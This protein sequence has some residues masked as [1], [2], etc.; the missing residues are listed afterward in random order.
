MLSPQRITY[1][2]ILLCGAGVLFLIGICAPLM[3][4]TKLM[5][6]TTTVSLI[7]AVWQLFAER[8]YVLGGVVGVF[9]LLGPLGKLT[10]VFLAC[11]HAKRSTLPWQRTLYWLALWG[12]WSMLD[13]FIVALLV[14]AAKVQGFVAVNVNYGLYAFAASVILLHVAT[15]WAVAEAP[16]SPFDRALGADTT[17]DHTPSQGVS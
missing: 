10:L 2:Y 9:C 7:S 4:V 14:V 5:I 12:K 8:H 15:C 11:R 1:I 13:V 3:T 6:F 17:S 16:R